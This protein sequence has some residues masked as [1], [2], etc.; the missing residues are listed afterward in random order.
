MELAEIVQAVAIALGAGGAGAGGSIFY[1]RSRVVR[2]NGG[3]S[4][5][6]HLDDIKAKLTANGEAIAAIKAE[7]H[8]VHEASNEAHRRLDRVLLNRK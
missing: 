5:R 3:E 7:L 2:P 6:D 4:V 8:D 1:T